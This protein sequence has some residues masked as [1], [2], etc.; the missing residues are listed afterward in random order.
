VTGATK[1]VAV[2]CATSPVVTEQI[3]ASERGVGGRAMENMRV[4]LKPP[5]RVFFSVQIE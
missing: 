5:D 1:A 3:V 2:S 4:K